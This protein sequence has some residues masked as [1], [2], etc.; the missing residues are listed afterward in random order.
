MAVSQVS[1]DSTTPLPHTALVQLGSVPD[2][3]PLGQQ[4]SLGPHEV[5]LV[6][7]Q[8]AVQLDAMPN[9]VSAVQLLLSLHEVGQ[10]EGGSQVSPCST[11]PLPQRGWQ[12]GSLFALQV[13][14]QHPSDKLQLVMGVCVH[15]AVHEATLPTSR[16][17]VQGSVSAQLDGQAPV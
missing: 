7:L 3:Q 5:M 14:G 1:P 10:L 6:C 12:S 13:A 16:S 17:V 4:P 2:P 15:A 8:L 11:T 9:R